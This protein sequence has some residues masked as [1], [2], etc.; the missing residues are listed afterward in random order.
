VKKMLM[1]A[2]LL[3]F[4]SSGWAMI[5]E[6]DIA[7]F[8]FAPQNLMV[9]QGDTVRWTN[10]DNVSHTSTSDDGIWDSG[11]LN[12]GQS[13]EYIFTDVGSFSYYCTVHP[14][15]T[16]AVIVEAATGIDDQPSLS[17]PEGF[18]L[19]PNYPNPFNASTIIRFATDK[20]AYATLEVYDITGRR[21][22]VLQNGMVNAGEHSVIWDGTGKS[23]GVYF[24]R[25]SLNGKSATRAMVLVK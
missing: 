5:H 12:N 14:S 15:M 18:S 7:N 11:I 17:L 22:D 1:I 9:T 25:L 6:V 8:A 10:Q 19:Q 13:F 2:L 23:T 4:S 21:V 20:E 16:G 3:A 24:Y